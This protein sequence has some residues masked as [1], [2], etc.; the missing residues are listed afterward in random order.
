MYWDSE[1]YA[2]GI[3][4]SAA[5]SSIESL[6]D[7]LDTIIDNGDGGVINDA[8]YYRVGESE[9]DTTDPDE[10]NDREIAQS[11]MDINDKLIEL[12]R[13][14]VEREREQGED[15]VFHNDDEE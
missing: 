15:T 13:A 3:C 10:Q 6:V 2:E 5:G 1:A 14:I 12:R 7:V 8:Y 9:E 4:N 11:Y